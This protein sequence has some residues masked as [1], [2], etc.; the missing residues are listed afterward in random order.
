MAIIGVLA[1]LLLPAVN[2]A[3]EAA[4]KVSC[5]NRLRQLG[6]A[7][8]EYEV[9]FKYFPAGRMDPDYTIGRVA[10]VGGTTYPISIPKGGWTGFRSVHTFLLPFM[11]ARPVYDRI[12]FSAP[13]AV[14]MIDNSGR[15]V[16]AN[17][18]AYFYADAMFLCPSEINALRRITE[19][20]YRYN[21]GGSTP[22]GGAENTNDNSNYNASILGLSCMGNGAFTIGQAL[23]TSAFTDGLSNTVVFSERCMGSGADLSRVKA[24]KT[25]VNVLVNRS[26]TL[27]TPDQF[28]NQCDSR[29]YVIDSFN[30]NSMGRWLGGALYSNGWP[31]AFYSSTMYNHVAPPNWKKIDCGQRSAIPDR[32]GEHA[33]I[34]AR[35]YHVGGVNVTFGDSSTRFISD[36]IDLE[37][38][39]SVGSRNGGEQTIYR[40]ELSN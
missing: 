22:Y 21:F 6:L 38:W 11:D 7:M 15:P 9:N 18:N 20:N 14:Q 25:D 13:T 2:S 12:N 28:F 17:Y 40:D 34:S 5:V 33:I 23:G 10:Q 29:P 8:S 27:L 24:Q 1:G 4:R 3:R 36:S 30:F 35:S 31:F 39:R 26:F 19:N 32:P 16:N 37:T